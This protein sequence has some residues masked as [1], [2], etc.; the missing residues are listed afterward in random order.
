MQTKLNEQIKNS[1]KVKKQFDEYKK[2]M[3]GAVEILA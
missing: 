3:F 2:C 1:I